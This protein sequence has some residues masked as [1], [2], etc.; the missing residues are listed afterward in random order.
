M[1]E[2]TGARYAKGY[3][4]NEILLGGFD[5]V[6]D[7]VGSD[8]S[9]QDALRWTRGGGRVVLAGINWRP[10][11]VDYS[12][13]WAQ[14]VE[15]LGINCHASEQGG[16]TSFDIAARLLREGCL[17]PGDIITHRFPVAQYK[18]AVK[19]FLNKGASGAI[20]IVLEHGE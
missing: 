3:F 4:G 2:R 19:A 9:L 20:K 14:E 7:T 15:L 8:R 10:G 16:E 5:T 17:V 12:P 13:V 11:K 18:K 6:Y 1:A